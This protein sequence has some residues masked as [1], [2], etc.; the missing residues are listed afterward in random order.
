M[1]QVPAN[2]YYWYVVEYCSV[3]NNACFVIRDD[4]SLWNCSRVP[5]KICG[6]TVFVTKRYG[7]ILHVTGSIQCPRAGIRRWVVLS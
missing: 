5:V 3:C 6:Y 7:D 2:S 1:C 4:S